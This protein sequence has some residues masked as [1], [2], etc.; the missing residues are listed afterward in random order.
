[1]ADK[2]VKISGGGKNLFKVSSYNGRYTVYEVSVSM[3]PVFDNY[4]KIGKAS[5]LDD[6][7]SLIKAHSGKSIVSIS[8]W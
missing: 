3:L 1:M 7:L 5:S 8:D 2:K 6:A 4:K